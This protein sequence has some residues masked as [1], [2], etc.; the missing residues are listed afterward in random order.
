MDPIEAPEFSRYLQTLKRR[1]YQ[2]VLVAGPVAIL[3]LVLALALPN[4]YRSEE[5]INIQ[6]VRSEG[7]RSADL[8]SDASNLDLYVADL[9]QTALGKESMTRFLAFMHQS[10]AS[11]DDLDA[12][13]EKIKTKINIV[14]DTVK[15]LDLRS[16]RLREVTTGFTV[17]FDAPAA[18]QARQGT[19]WIANA[20]L[21]AHRN[22]RLA[23]AQSAQTFLGAEVNRAQAE[24]TALETKM[25]AF[26][27][28]NLGRLPDSVSS[29][30]AAIDRAE[31]ELEDL[32]AQSR[33]LR[34]QRIFLANRLDQA[35]A[36]PDSDRLRELQDEYNRL[37]LT[38]D[39]NHPDLVTLQR[40]IDA[41]KNNTAVGGSTLQSQL[42][43]Q[44]ALL[45]EVRQ[46]YSDEHPDVKKIKRDI[47]NLEARIAA[48]EKDA[49]EAASASPAEVQL[50]TEINATDSQ[51]A[52][53]DARSAELR[54][55]LNVYQGRV[56]STPQVE[57]EYA[58]LSRNL[59]AARAQYQD[60][61]NRKLAAGVSAAAATAGRGGDFEL[62]VAQAASLPE[63]P[64]APIRPLFV[65]AGLFGG[66]VLG[67]SALLA[68]EILSTK[69]RDSKDLRDLLGVAPLGLVPQ[70]RNSDWR[71]RH[72]RW[73]MMTVGGM[74]A[75]AVLVFTLIKLRGR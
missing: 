18:D 59:E 75:W 40:Q 73:R 29:N 45:A 7:S 27:Q 37:S 74:A 49:P 22:N 36:A 13:I 72:A 19:A 55:S 2:F 62:R 63:K 65:L 16:G 56:A 47:A 52:S 67:I 5:T 24:L 26:K 71:A 38:Y 43:S 44:R 11:A 1:R 33:S 3:G 48:G 9:S 17:Q 4:K 28:Q 32:L 15:V 51:L 69:V 58:D 57:R 61:L 25:A 30:Q 8:D 66:L 34:Q 41:L 39:K 12:A 35:K 23:D 42:E 70:I 54:N 20:F 31:R 60:L 50:Q 10:P 6:N 68:L 46:R 64:H 14:S 21:E 53:I